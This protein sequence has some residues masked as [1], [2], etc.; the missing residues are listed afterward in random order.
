MGTSVLV[1]ITSVLVK[2][3]LG[4]CSVFHATVKAATHS[5]AEENKGT[6]EHWMLCVQ[7]Q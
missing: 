3:M 4:A 5:M 6:H 2:T 1:T 7:T